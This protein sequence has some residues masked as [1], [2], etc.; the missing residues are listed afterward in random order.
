M[1][2]YFIKINEYRKYIKSLLKGKDNAI[3]FAL[4]SLLTGGHIIIEDI[5]GLGKTTLALILAKSLH[6]SFGRIQGTNDLL[7]SDILG[8]NM[9]DKHDG[10]V[11]FINGPIFNNIILF[12]EINRASP[13]TQSALLEAMEEN[14]VTLE[15]VTYPLPTPFFVIATQNPFDEY[16]TYPLP[17]SEWDRFQMRLSIGYPSNK[18]EIEILKEGSLKSTIPHIQPIINQDEIIEIQL[19]IEKNIYVSESIYEFIMD[20]ANKTRQS[21]EILIGLSTRACLDIVKLA[22]A[23]A[24]V[25]SR[26]YVIPEDVLD[27]SNLTMI[28]RIIFK[29]VQKIID[30]EAILKSVLETVKNPL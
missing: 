8:Y 12:D 16:G 18:S 11:R 6:L 4:L 28:H 25:M 29:N 9:Y 15:G 19:L 5:P 3:D 17:E 20:I 27:L 10:N 21:D 13:K 22:K 14:S 7:P 2:N 1:D 26:D 24:F 30:K 23:R